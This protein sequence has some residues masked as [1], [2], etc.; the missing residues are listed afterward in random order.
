MTCDPPTT[1]GV[2][3]RYG[4]WAFPTAPAP[5]SFS[6]AFGRRDPFRNSSTMTRCAKRRSKELRDRCA[7]LR[8]SIREEREVHIENFELRSC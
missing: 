7:D 1:T 3:R 4:L 8:R 6:S 2:R 5:G